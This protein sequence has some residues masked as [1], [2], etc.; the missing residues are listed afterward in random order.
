MV[1]YHRSDIIELQDLTVNLLAEVCC[2]V[3]VEPDLQPL[4][5]ES[6][7]YHSAV[8]NDEARL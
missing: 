2:D 8:T 6:L 7:W 3:A 4:T 5:G 1:A